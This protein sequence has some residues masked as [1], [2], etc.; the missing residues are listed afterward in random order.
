MLSPGKEAALK[1]NVLNNLLL[2]FK[3]FKQY[4]MRKEN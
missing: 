2:L 1:T 3:M 4:F